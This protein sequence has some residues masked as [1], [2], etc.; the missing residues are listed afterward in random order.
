MGDILSF[1]DMA[2]GVHRLSDLGR[3]KPVGHPSLQ[4]TRNG[5]VLLQEQQV[6]VELGTDMLWRIIRLTAIRASQYP[7]DVAIAAYGNKGH[8]R[9][10]AEQT[11]RTQMEVWEEAV[12]S[13]KQ[14]P[15]LLHHSQPWMEYFQVDPETGQRTDE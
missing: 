14:L 8:V 13:R 15:A 9:I 6:W 2:A 11:L 1:P 5:K 10:I 12:Q 3:A 4:Y 7:F